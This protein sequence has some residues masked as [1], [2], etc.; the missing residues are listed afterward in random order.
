MSSA[1]LQVTGA[2][3]PEATLSVNGA[4][5][6]VD[7]QGNFS[8]TI[9]LEEGPNLVEVVASDYDGNEVSSLLEIVYIP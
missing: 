2:T 1:S 6:G 3:I 4:S 8:T 9:Q 5:V 7:G